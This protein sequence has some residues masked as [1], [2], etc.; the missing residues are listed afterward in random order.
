MAASDIQKAKIA[1]GEIESFFDCLSDILLKL[2]GGTLHKKSP[3][4][5]KKFFSSYMICRYISMKE[6]LI[7][8]AEVLNVMQGTL[9]S[10]DFYQLAYNII[11]KQRSGFIK[12]LKK[13]KTEITEEEPVIINDIMTTKN[14]L[15]DL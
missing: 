4:L 10:E 9:S 2:S 3:E 13:K 11:P 6:E 8:Y 5:F 14:T 7:D 1:A 12:Y 15:F